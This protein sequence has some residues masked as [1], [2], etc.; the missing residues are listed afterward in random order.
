MERTPDRRPDGAPGGAP[1]RVPDGMI[2]HASGSVS[3]GVPGPGLQPGA[4]ARIAAC[5]A[6]HAGLAVPD[7]VIDAR[8]RERMAALGIESDAAYADLL[9]APGSAGERAI[10]VEALRVGETRFFRHQAHVRAL[11]DVVAPA[12]QRRLGRA[13]GS[14][15]V[16]RA[17]S[18]G[19]A[20]G[21]EAYTLAMILGSELAGWEVRVLATDVS[22][23]ALEVARAGVYPA[24]VAAH[25]PERW[26]RDAFAPAGDRV[27]IAPALRRRVS[28]VHHNLVDRGEPARWEPVAA[29]AGFDVIWCRNVLMYLGPDARALVAARLARGLAAHG[30]LFLGHAETLRE[31]RAFT[32][33]RAAGAVLY[34]R[35]APAGPRHEAPARSGSAS[36]RARDAAEPVVAPA[37]GRGEAARA[38][39][40]V[41][42][43]GRYGSGDRLAREL[44]AAMQGAHA[45]VIVDLDGATFLGDA[46]AAVLRRAQRA[47]RA[48]GAEVQV[49]A[50]RPGA[51]RWLRRHGLDRDV[52]AGA[53]AATR[54]RGGGAS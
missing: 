23:R 46:A 8:A 53:R 42:L 20:T 34:R 43:A 38:A 28:F 35:A 39:R 41:K 31:G 51:R 19:C 45:R 5:L 33:A 12:L 2:D 1:E 3:R 47:A 13:P 48:A 30:F 18:A 11:V 22:E 36:S 17:W 52:H 7:W 44:R 32:A 29:G 27:R 50:T 15:R 26:R 21:E 49:R 6:A 4:R 40:E 16:V 25:V 54:E 24:G 10:L 14:R 9:A 37:P